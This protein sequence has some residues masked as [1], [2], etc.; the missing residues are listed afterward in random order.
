MGKLQESAQLQRDTLARREALDGTPRAHKLAVTLINLA[1]TE[2]SLGEL[3]EARKWADR[4]FKLA[5][6]YVKEDDP[7]FGTIL[8]NYGMVLDRVGSRSEA[9]EYFE[10]ALDLRLKQDDTQGAIEALASLAAAFYDTG[11]YDE[12]DQRYTEAY[13]LAQQ[14]LPPLH[15]VRGQIA[16][17][18][19]RVLSSIGKLQQSLAICDEAIKVFSAHPEDQLQVHFTQINRGVTL[20]LL[21][22]APEAISTLRA[23]VLALRQTLPAGSPEVFEA[24]RSLG[25][26]FIDSGNVDEGAT[27]LSTVLEEE[28]ALLGPLHPDVLLTQ[29][30]YGVVLAMQGKLREAEAVLTDYATK[31]DT[32]RGLYG[33]NERTIRGV[34]SRFASTRMFLAKLMIAGGRCQAAF[35]LIENTKARSLADRIRDQASFA[36][37]TS[38]EREVFESLEQS[39]T[40]LFIE[41]AQADGN[42]GK[43]TEIDGRLR[44]IDGQLGKLIETVRNRSA[45]VGTP[46]LPSAAIL[47]KP[48]APNTIL[49]SFAVADDEILVVAFRANS[50]FQC[51]SLGQWTGLTDTIWATRTLQSTP[52]GLQGLLAGSPGTPA[53]RIVKT[54]TRSF[55]LL[56]REDPIPVEATVVNSGA[57]ILSTIG[58][59]LAGWLVTSAGASTRLVISPDGILNL[60]AFDALTVAGHPLISRFSISQVDSFALPV[61]NEKR[62]APPQDRWSM[63]AFGDPVYANATTASPEKAAKR[64]AQVLR[65]LIADGADWPKLPASEMELSSLSALFTL[66]PGKSLFK[67]E[68]ANTR[69]LKR[70]DSDGTLMQARY[71]VFSAHAFADLSDPEVSSVVLSVPQGGAAR[72]AYFTATELAALKLNADLVYFSACETGY[73]QVVSGEGVISLSS[74]ALVAGARSTIH[75]LW[76]VVD[77]ATAEFTKR[78]FTAVRRGVPPEEALTRTKR[79]F[80]V[81]PRHSSPAYWASYVLVQARW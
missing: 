64:S 14:R 13:S 22:R 69:N 66:V 80:S 19:C 81:E 38:A 57:N 18:W 32:M 53:S 6:K 52:A 17:S 58:T 37:A 49:A 50:G 27:L 35:D 79:E 42:G 78:F 75:T 48:A 44:A 67:N 62:E 28:Q 43:Q 61:R 46:N 20:G 76:S 55:A 15:S 1:M 73:G 30:N 3:A 5:Q 39:R 33:R 2:S 23:A 54:G 45:A 72:D 29:G 60:I 63:I 8:H 59:E 24:V 31:A 34:F 25:V 70:L 47:R 7:R 71:L 21:G 40:R 51:T 10:R 68:A 11:R 74:A 12:S 41:R 77:S 16:R 56:A 4:G 65:G 26:V 9:Q 36:S